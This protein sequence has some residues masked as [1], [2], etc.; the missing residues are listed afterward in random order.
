MKILLLEDNA[1][2]NATIVKRLEAKGYH[3]DSFMDGQ[4]AYDALDNGY[5]CFI[6]DINVPTL[7]GIEILKKIRDFYPETPVIIMSSSVELEVIKDAYNFGC[8]DFLKKPFFIDELEIKIEKLCN[9]RH[10]IVDLG[11]ECCFDF[12]TSLLRI[13]Q[14]Q[15]EHL[16]RKEKLLLNVLISEK[17]KV[18]TFDKIQ[19]MVWEGNFASL[20]SIRSLMRR[21]RKKIPFECIETVVDVGYI[22]R[23]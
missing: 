17:G 20:D 9:I 21:L 18:V 14:E 19:A 23:Y 3:I 8:N 11:H 2:F 5:A 10:D 7:D 22:L 4:E 13:G 15:E 6:L 1:R 16:S 12:K